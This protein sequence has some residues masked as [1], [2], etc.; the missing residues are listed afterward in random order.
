[1]AVMPMM[2][3]HTVECDCCV[4]LIGI[5]YDCDDVAV[6]VR[7]AAEQD[8]G[9]YRCTQCGSMI[10]VRHVKAGMAATEGIIGLA[11]HTVTV[12]GPPTVH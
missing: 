11:V 12:T 9:N 6:M 3:G 4:M 10:T 1:M 8:G 2:I 7:D 5:Q